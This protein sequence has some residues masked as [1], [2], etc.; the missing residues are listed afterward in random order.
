MIEEERSQILAILSK[1]SET[2][3][4]RTDLSLVTLIKNR[5]E[6]TDGR[7]QQRYNIRERE[8]KTDRRFQQCYVH[9]EGEKTVTEIENDFWHCYMNRGRKCDR[10]HIFTM[11]YESR[12]GKKIENRFLHW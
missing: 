6:K 8:K 1:S 11:L 12:E 7:F 3:R 5:K 4:H 9:R 10:E 2:T